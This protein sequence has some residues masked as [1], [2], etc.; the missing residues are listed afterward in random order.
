MARFVR[1]FSL[2]SLITASLVSNT[3]Y[4]AATLDAVQMLRNIAS[5]L[6]PWFYVVTASFY[7][8]GAGLIYK[9]LYGLK[10]YGESRTMMSSNASLKEPLTVATVGV[11][12]LY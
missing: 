10:I 8:L 6:Q 11:A 12:F 4:A 7:I 9:A 2:S 1:Y 5:Q 3:A